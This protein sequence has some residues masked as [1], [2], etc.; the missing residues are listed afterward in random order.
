MFEANGSDVE[1]AS[2]FANFVDVI[3]L[4]ARGEVAG[5]DATGELDDA[6]QSGGDAMRNPGGSQSGEDEGN[7]RSGEEIAAEDV[8]RGG[9]LLRSERGDAGFLV[10]GVVD[11]VAERKVQDR[12]ADAEHEDKGKEE[13]GKDFSGHGEIQRSGFSVQRSA[14]RSSSKLPACTGYEPESEIHSLL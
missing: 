4:N 12:R 8:Q 1:G 10:E 6:V 11:D 7:Q 5:S 13:F 3:L 9:L 14:E 2:D